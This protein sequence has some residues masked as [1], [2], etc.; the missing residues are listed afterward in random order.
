MFNDL[1]RYEAVEKLVAKDFFQY[2]SDV[3]YKYN[4]KSLRKE[5]NNLWKKRKSEEN[6]LCHISA[7]QDGF[8]EDFL[9]CPKEHQEL[10]SLVMGVLAEVE[11][12]VTIAEQNLKK[13]K[14]KQ[15]MIR[16]S[17]QSGMVDSISLEQL[18]RNE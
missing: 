8:L 7:I 1:M 9:L 5:Y 14:L 10:T 18:I 2:M 15:M 12:E 6:P 17:I 11:E 3:G 4:T 16:Y 13:A